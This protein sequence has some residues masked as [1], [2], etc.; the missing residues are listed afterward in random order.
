MNL[1]TFYTKHET[2]I[3]IFAGIAAIAFIVTVVLFGT[4]DFSVNQ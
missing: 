3:K 4:A 1:K 2:G